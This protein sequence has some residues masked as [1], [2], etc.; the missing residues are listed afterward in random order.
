M[1]R[2]RWEQL[3]KWESGTITPQSADLPNRSTVGQNQ[4]N[5]RHKK[6]PVSRD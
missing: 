5:L 4:V 1:E 6:F 2:E 3:G